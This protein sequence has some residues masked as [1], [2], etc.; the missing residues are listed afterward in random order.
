M[1]AKDLAVEPGDTIDLGTIDVTSDERPE[2]VRTKAAGPEADTATSSSDDAIKL[3]QYSGQVVDSD[4]N[5]VRGAKIHFVYWYSHQ[6]APLNSQP[7]ATTGQDGRFQFEMARSD[8][9]Q[10]GYS[11]PPWR[12]GSLVASAEGHGVAWAWS[13][14]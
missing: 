7:V 9:H 3:L 11:V 5:P 14:P 4:G 12:R 8:F 6:D 1:V 2:P 10:T 13:M